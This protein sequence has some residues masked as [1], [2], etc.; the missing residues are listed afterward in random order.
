MS[1]IKPIHVWVRCITPN[2]RS[3]P[4]FRVWNGSLMLSAQCIDNERG[5]VFLPIG[6]PL[7]LSHSNTHMHSHTQPHMHAPFYYNSWNFKSKQ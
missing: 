3:P 2:S 1:N 4:D 5:S 6:S 7:C